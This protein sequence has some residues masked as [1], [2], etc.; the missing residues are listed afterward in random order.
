MRASYCARDRRNGT[1]KATSFVTA[2]AARRRLPAARG[3]PAQG[4]RGTCASAS[5]SPGLIRRA[6]TGVSRRPR[7]PGLRHAQ[8]DVESCSSRCRPRP[9]CAPRVTSARTLRPGNRHVR[10]HRERGQRRR[11]ASAGGAL[12]RHD[13]IPVRENQR[14]PNERQTIA[15]GPAT[16][17]HQASRTILRWATNG[18]HHDLGHSSVHRET[19]E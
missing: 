11:L 5:C 10:P 6:R 4:V 14:L 12:Q 9:A 7:A 1:S 16:A 19:T 18:E 2:A 3:Q 17:H 15:K 13:F 8:G